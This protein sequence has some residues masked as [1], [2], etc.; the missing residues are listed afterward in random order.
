MLTPLNVRCWEHLSLSSLYPKIL[1]I[2]YFYIKI[3]SPISTSNADNSAAYCLGR[4][5]GDCWFLYTLNHAG[6][7]SLVGVREPDQTL[8]ILMQD[9]DHDIMKQ[10]VKYNDFGDAISATELTQVT[11][12]MKFLH[13]YIVKS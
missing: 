5:N 10:F 1:C 12:S 7:D 11:T 4:L 9:L 2:F 6:N 8:E 13:L 3:I